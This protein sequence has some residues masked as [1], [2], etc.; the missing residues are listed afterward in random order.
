[1]QK[2][3]FLVERDGKIVMQ[4]MRERAKKRL[5][6][7]YLRSDDICSLSHNKSIRI[8]GRSLWIFVPGVPLLVAFVRYFFL[9]DLTHIEQYK[10]S[11]AYVPT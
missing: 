8:Q 10:Y 3:I 9:R 1:M 6:Q 11:E 5:T 4:E 7:Q 2:G